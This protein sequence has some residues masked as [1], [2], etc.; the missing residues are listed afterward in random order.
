MLG[1]FVAKTVTFV[2]AVDREHF[3]QIQS[4]DLI[5]EDLHKNHFQMKNGIKTNMLDVNKREF[6][7]N[8]KVALR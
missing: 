1:L 8:W 6:M 4:R 3:T 5:E 7:V 2:T